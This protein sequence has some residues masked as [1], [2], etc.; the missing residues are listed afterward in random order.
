MKRVNKLFAKQG[1]ILSASMLYTADDEY[2]GDNKMI[3]RET[4]GYNMIRRVRES[5]LQWRG[6][7]KGEK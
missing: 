2:V 7:R 5:F 6:L 4:N 3:D 1:N